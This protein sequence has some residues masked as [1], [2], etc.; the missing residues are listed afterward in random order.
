MILSSGCNISHKT[1]LG[2]EPINGKIQ[3]S[4]SESYEKYDVPSTPQ[5]ILSL[6]T[7]KI[8]GCMNYQIAN[9]STIKNGTVDVRISGVIIPEICLTALGPAT[10]ETR[11][12]LPNGNYK[13]ILHS[14]NFSNSYNL[15]IADRSISIDQSTY[16]ETQPLYRLYWR[17][18]PNS[19]VYMCGTLLQ[20]STISTDFLDTLKS[21]IDLQ[22][23]VFPDSGKVP[24][25]TASD[26]HYYDMPAKYFYYKSETDFDKIGNIM[27]DY[28][29]KYLS[30]KTGYGISI[31][32]WMNKSFYSWLL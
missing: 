7:E 13:L 4:I 16:S 22:E 24:Y 9:T 27:K 21:K 17:Y 15:S 31:V 23:F 12:D 29:A 8:Y 25:P 6:K 32:S 19:F 11:L 14:G 28:K 20:D 1:H 18:P 2:Q 3:F 26:G 30:N 10:A 5:I